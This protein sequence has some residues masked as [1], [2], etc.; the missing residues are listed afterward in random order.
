MVMRD[1]GETQKFITSWG[2]EGAPVVVMIHGSVQ[3]SPLGGADHFSAQKDLASRGWR[4]VAPDRAGHGKS[5]KQDHPDDVDLEGRWVSN[6][7]QNGAHLVG[8][9][10]GGAIA[11]SATAQRP[12]AVRSLTLIEPA[13]Q[14]MALTHPDVQAFIAKQIALFSSNRPAAEVAAEFTKMAGIPESIRDRGDKPAMI[15][16]GESLRAI[17]WPAPP[18]F[19]QYAETIARAGVPVLVVSGGWNPAFE[20]TCDVVARMTGGQRRVIQSPHHF[21]NLVSGEF[22]DVLHDFMTEGATRSRT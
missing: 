6:L 3:G 15:G 16:L 7:L 22:N 10:L 9:S 17:R 4:I 18:A 21:P 8:H 5:P 11:F 1:G 19:A 20:A 14:M 13:L 12:D 2:E